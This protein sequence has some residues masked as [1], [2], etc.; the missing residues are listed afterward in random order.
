MTTNTRTEHDLLGSLEIPAD[1]LFGVQ[2]QR[3]VNNFPLTNKKLAQYPTLINAICYVKIAS[4][5]ANFAQRK[6]SQSQ[7][8]LLLTCCNEIISG[9]H[10]EAFVVDMIQGG[11]GTSTNMNANEVIANLALEKLGHNKGDYQYFHPNDVVNLS[12]STN[13]VYPSS[14]RLACLL[15]Q[16]KLETALLNLAKSFRQQAAN[17]TDVLK[18]GRTQLQDAVPM[19]VSQELASFATY[20]ENDVKA[21]QRAAAEM[22]EVNL[23]G[24]AIGTGITTLAGYQQLAVDFLAQETKL[25][26]TLASDLIAASSDMGAF[27]S[28]SSALKRIALKLSKIANDL[29]LLSMGPRAGIGELSLPAKQPGSSIMPGK[30]NPVIPEAVSQAAF[31]VAGMDAAV[32]MAAE[33]AQL[34]LNAMEPL[35][36]LNI[37]DSMSLL[38]NTAVMFKVDCVD[39]LVVNS[40]RCEALLNKSLATVTAIN[41]YVGYAVASK[42][43]KTALQSGK[44]VKQVI[45]ESNIMS[46]QALE[47]LMSKQ[48]LTEPFPLQ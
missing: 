11:A 8:D 32:G 18:V 20:I 40:E 27:I 15:A 14:I 34:Q 47:A 4:A 5:R 29:R 25:A 24:T 12:Q 2:T 41:P 7:F 35:I 46:A 36:G 28:Y 44:S 19:T 13:D 31:Q 17:C 30:I 37:L 48:A 42:V 6:L 45:D 9:D 22:L 16:P 3:A 10:H 39:E 38:T 1:A 23:G 33:A 21:L 26:F 43:A